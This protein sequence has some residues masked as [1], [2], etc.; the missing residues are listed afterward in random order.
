MPNETK[1]RP[2]YEAVIAIL[3][4]QP[5]LPGCRAKYTLAE[6][7]E[8]GAVALSKEL[9]RGRPAEYDPEDSIHCDACGDDITDAVLE[10]YNYCPYCGQKL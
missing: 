3:R 5:M 6:A 9:P 8:I 1:P 4:A 2:D 7:C 10:D